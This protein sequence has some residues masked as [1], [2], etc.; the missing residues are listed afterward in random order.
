MDPIGTAG[1]GGSAAPPQRAFLSHTSDL[2]MHTEPGSFVAA[3]VAAVLRARHA[4]TDM[5]YFGARDTDLGPIVAD[6][7]GRETISR[8]SSVRYSDGRRRAGAW[9]RGARLRVRW[10]KDIAGAPR[11]RASAAT[12]VIRRT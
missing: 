3:T 4:V 11:C 1:T 10:L 8:S 9:K 5:A 6:L 7:V 2:G 12:T